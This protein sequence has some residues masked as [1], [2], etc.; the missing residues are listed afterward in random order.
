MLSTFRTFFP[1]LLTLIPNFL[2]NFTSLYIWEI[3]R[4]F[5]FFQVRGRL[6][7]GCAAQERDAR[8]DGDAQGLAERAQEEPLPDQGREDHAGHHHKNDAHAGEGM[9]TLLLLF[10]R[11]YSVCPD[12]AIQSHTIESSVAQKFKTLFIPEDIMWEYSIF[13]THYFS[14]YLPGEHLVR[15]RP[16]PPEEGE[17]DD[18]G[19][20]EQAGR[21]GRGGVGRRRKGPQGRRQA[22]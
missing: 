19:A 16:P 14:F 7:P 3:L 22:R 13:N 8:V 2:P 21:R 1:N 10:F 5:P 17:Q 15:E 4:S 20:Q 11:K 9:K 12:F 6:R 18:L